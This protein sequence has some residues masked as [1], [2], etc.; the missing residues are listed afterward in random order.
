M[1]EI[2][3]SPEQKEITY[4][5]FRKEINEVLMSSKSER[6]KKDYV[7]KIIKTQSVS[8]ENYFIYNSEGI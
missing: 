2:Q 4:K 1:E 8:Y 5:S 3:L 6:E 7:I